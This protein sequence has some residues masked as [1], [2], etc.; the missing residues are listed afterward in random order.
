MKLEKTFVRTRFREVFEFG[1]ATI[2]DA[3]RK[4]IYYHSS[5][6]NHTTGGGLLT[7]A[8]KKQ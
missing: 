7:M 5:W 1:F 6:G 3:R 2:F 4:C 8:P